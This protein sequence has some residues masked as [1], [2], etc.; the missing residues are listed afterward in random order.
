MVYLETFVDH[1]TEP[2][3]ADAY[4]RSAGLCLPHLRQALGFMKNP[5]T[6]E[7]LRKMEAER[8]HQLEREL[9]EFIRKHDYRFADE[10]YGEERDAWL[11]SLEKISGKKGIQWA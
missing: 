1:L 4:A 7:V 2:D 10:S 11:R 8:L 5:H 3:F 6:F 9:T